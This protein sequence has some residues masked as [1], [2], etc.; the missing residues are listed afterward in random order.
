MPWCRTRHRA[1]GVRR[2][3]F[4]SGTCTHKSCRQF[5][6]PIAIR[7]QGAPENAGGAHLP[8]QNAAGE[9]HAAS[10][11]RSAASSPWAAGRPCGVR[12][13]PLHPHL[14]CPC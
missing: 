3:S 2:C 10:G 13:P 14:A 4:S 12:S 1:V 7:W 6:H 9:A 5:C 8:E 11:P